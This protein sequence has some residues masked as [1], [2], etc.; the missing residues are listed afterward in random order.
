MWLC[1]WESFLRY[2]CL[3]GIPLGRPHQYP[4]N[5]LPYFYPCGSAGGTC[6]VGHAR[7]AHCHRAT[8]PGLFLLY[9]LQQGLTMLPKPALDL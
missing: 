4:L 2:L 9:V 8:S 7:Q 6:G 1:R 3:L 5:F